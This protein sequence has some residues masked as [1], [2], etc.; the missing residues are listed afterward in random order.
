MVLARLHAWIHSAVGWASLEAPRRLCSHVGGLM[1]LW[2]VSLPLSFS[3]YCYSTSLPREP[4]TPGR[5][6]RSLSSRIVGPPYSMVAGL[7]GVFSDF[8]LCP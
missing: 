2:V 1:F 7:M 6:M 8:D 3:S 4:P 5:S